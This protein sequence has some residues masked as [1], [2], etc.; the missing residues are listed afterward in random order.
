MRRRNGVRSSTLSASRW[1]RSMRALR[2]L[3]AVLGLLALHFLVHPAA[4]AET[5]PS[6]PV[7]FIVG[8]T[9]GGPT[10]IV[11][12]IISEWLSDHLGQQF[13]VENRAGSGGMIAS[14]AQR[15]R[16]H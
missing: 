12:R 8:F 15:R 7:H 6:R 13:V 1:S 16:V 5:Y 11:A 9:A 4:R 10:D 3:T 2:S 14:G